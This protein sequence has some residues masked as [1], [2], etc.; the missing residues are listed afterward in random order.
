MHGFGK[1]TK[2]LLQLGRH[3]TAT[4]INWQWVFLRRVKLRRK[5]SGASM[6]EPTNVNWSRLENSLKFRELELKSRQP[7]LQNKP[8][9]LVGLGR[10]PWSLAC[11]CWSLS[12]LPST[13]FFSETGL[14][15]H[16]MLQ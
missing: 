2:N 11:C 12:A 3:A 10:S 14:P 15:M 13:R 9:L 7:G 8:D 16:S 1:S 6:N 4:P 5:N